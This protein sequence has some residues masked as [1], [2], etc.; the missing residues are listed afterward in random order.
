MF[1]EVRFCGGGIGS[2][3]I[4]VCVTVVKDVPFEEVK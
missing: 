3:F 2:V 1:K 4:G